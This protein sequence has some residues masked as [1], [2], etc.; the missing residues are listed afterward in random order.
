MPDKQQNKKPQPGKGQQTNKQDN[1][2]AT[3]SAPKKK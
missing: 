3:Q 1:K 2:K